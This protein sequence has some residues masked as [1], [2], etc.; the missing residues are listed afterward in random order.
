MRKLFFA[1]LVFLIIFTLHSQI[2]HADENETSNETELITTVECF[3]D[4]CSYF[5]GSV[6]A[7]V[8]I[9]DMFTMTGMGN[10]SLTHIETD[11]MQNDSYDFSCRIPYLNLTETQEFVFLLVGEMNSKI[12]SQSSE[13]NDWK[14]NVTATT[15]SLAEANGSIFIL[16]IF[17]V[18]MGIAIVYMIKDNYW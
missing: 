12:E 6:L 11:T 5:H 4:F 13:I 17:I 14:D 15:I 9:P 3:G 7:Q 16:E 8:W 10:C 1:V 2:I 18:L